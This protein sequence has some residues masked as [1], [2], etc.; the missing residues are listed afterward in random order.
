MKTYVFETETRNLGQNNQCEAVHGKKLG[1]LSN[2]ILRDND[3][4]VEIR[5]ICS[6]THRVSIRVSKL[7]RPT[8][9][10]NFN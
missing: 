2:L 6:T 4:T 1:W 8:R 7:T 3:V 5:Y 10:D 9:L